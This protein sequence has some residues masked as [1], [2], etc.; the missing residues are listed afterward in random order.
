ME[1]KNKKKL[2]TWMKLLKNGAT[3]YFN[4]EEEFKNDN[5][6]QCIW[7]GTTDQ[8]I[9]SQKVNP[10]MNVVYNVFWEL[11]PLTNTAH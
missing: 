5:R 6:H 9:E 8:A 4:N 10:L 1:Y 7:A 3:I 2:Q 11:K